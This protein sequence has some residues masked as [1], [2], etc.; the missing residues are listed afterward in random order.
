M[1]ASPIS[2]P[3][4][5]WSCASTIAVRTTVIASS[6]YPPA[7]RASLGSPT[8][9]PRASASSWWLPMPRV[10]RTIN[11]P[12]GRGSNRKRRL[13]KRATR[14]IALCQALPVGQR[15]GERIVCSKP[16]GVHRRAIG[17]GFR[18]VPAITDA[19]PAL[20]E[21][22]RQAIVAQPL[23]QA[24]DH[25]AHVHLEPA[26]LT[27]DEALAFAQ[28]VNLAIGCAVRLRRDGVERQEHVLGEAKILAAVLGRVADKVQLQRA[29]SLDTIGVRE[30]LQHR[31]N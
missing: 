2:P 1:C 27:G 15:G 31:D 20:D 3:V 21:L 14:S 16:V 13:A 18:I 26:F 24:F 23:P 30:K 10:P 9:A 29:V 8:T 4:G 17:G 5:R 12:S 22:V 6:I 25:R 11:G 7:P 19:R 28:I